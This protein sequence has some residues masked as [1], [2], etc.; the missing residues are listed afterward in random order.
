[1]D[2]RHISSAKRQYS[3]LGVKL[4]V[5][6]VL[7]VLQVR[8]TRPDTGF[9]VL[10]DQGQEVTSYLMGRGSAGSSWLV[11]GGGGEAPAPAPAAPVSTIDAPA[12]KVLEIWVIDYVKIMKW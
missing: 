3:Y 1:M 6:P 8:S 7:V 9:E 2:S 11:A 4:C 5:C 10:G 12:K